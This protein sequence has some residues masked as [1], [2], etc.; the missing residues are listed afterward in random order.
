M[1]KNAVLKGS[2]YDKVNTPIT[3]EGLKNLTNEIKKTTKRKV[4][5]KTKSKNGK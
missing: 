2:L 1:L 4:E 3:N 5:G